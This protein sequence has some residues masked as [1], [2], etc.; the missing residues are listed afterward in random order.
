MYM[1][2]TNGRTNGR[3][4]WASKDDPRITPVGRFLR[5]HR[6]DELPQLFNVL[7]GDMNLVGPR[8]EQ[9]EIFDQLRRIIDVYPER[10]AVRPGITGWAQVNR[11]YDEGLDDV[12][13]K[14][15]LDLEYVRQ[16]SVAKDLVIIA[17]TPQVMLFK[18]GS[19]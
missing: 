11:G 16:Q 7:R 8:P 1:E 18:H 10:Q 4:L 19:Q 15:H 5:A 9:P 3:Q 6:L 13:H 12:R 2:G 14:L 17:K